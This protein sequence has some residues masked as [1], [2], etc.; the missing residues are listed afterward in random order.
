M[1]IQISDIRPDETIEIRVKDSPILKRPADSVDIHIH[2]TIKRS[3]D[4]TPKRPDARPRRRRAI[5]F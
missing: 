2:S 1:N 3:E 4:T 5:S